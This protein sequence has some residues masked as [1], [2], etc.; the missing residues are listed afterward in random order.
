MTGYVYGFAS[1]DKTVDGHDIVAGQFVKAKSGAYVPP[2][3]AYLIYTGSDN[4]FRAP[5][6]DGNSGG[7]ELPDRI[8]VRLLSSSGTVTAVG[9]L[10]GVTGDVTIERWFDLSGRPVE[11]VPAEPGLYLNNRGKK[12]M[13]K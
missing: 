9:T 10:D 8:K 11:G 2:F 6:R 5:S 12:I 4:T 13:I 7:P 1:R 3:R